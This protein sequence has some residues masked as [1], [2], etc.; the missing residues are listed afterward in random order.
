MYSIVV[1][2]NHVLFFFLISVVQPCCLSNK[3]FSLIT[4]LNFLFKYDSYE[5]ILFYLW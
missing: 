4:E 2:C 3:D 5:L 1:S